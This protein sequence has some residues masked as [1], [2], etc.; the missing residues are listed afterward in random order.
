VAGQIADFTTFAESTYP[1]FADSR[2]F[3]KSA[4]YKSNG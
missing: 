4:R 1:V 3:R 2:V